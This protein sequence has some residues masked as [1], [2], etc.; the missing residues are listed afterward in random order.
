MI[1]RRQRKPETGRATAL[2]LV[3]AAGLALA[4]CAGA[5]SAP[6]RW[7]HASSSPADPLAAQ[8]APSSNTA[9]AATPGALGLAPVSSSAL[10]AALDAAAIRDHLEE[11]QLIA[12]A[13]SGHRAAGTPGFDASVEYV[14]AR[15]ARAGY[16]VRRQTFRFPFSSVE[17]R[18]SVNLIAEL[19]GSDGSSI[20][21]LGAHLDS[22]VGSPG[23]NDNGSGSM[24]LLALAER[25][26]QFEPPRHTV[27]LAFWGAEESGRYGSA[28]YITSLSAA[29]RQ[30]IAAYLNF[31][32]LG[33]P[34]HIRFVYDERDAAPGSSAITEVFARYFEDIGLSWEPIDLEGDSDHG[35]FVNAEI[36]TGGLFSGGAEPKTDAQAARFGGTAG[37]PA[38]PCSHTACDTTA[39][40]SDIALDEMADAVAHALVTLTADEVSVREP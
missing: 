5:S 22:V 14:A 39:N 19:P 36:P 1:S 13:N 8:R 21:M 10:R 34:N 7:T 16:E 3:L 25:L 35:P 12:A 20:T 28:A 2:R 11:L 27:R 15:L 30:R 24:T 29:E 26:T 6:P 37:A 23:I 18:T 32:M 33:S 17:E 31:D 38:D 9:A 40:V 4:G